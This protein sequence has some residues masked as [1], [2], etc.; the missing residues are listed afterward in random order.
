MIKVQWCPVGVIPTVGAAL[1]LFVLSEFLPSLS[2]H[3]GSTKVVA[4]ITGPI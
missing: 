4:V 1:L 2:D 3:L